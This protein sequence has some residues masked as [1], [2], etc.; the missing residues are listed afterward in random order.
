MRRFNR[1]SV[2]DMMEE[3]GGPQR[4]KAEPARDDLSDVLPTD[5][6]VLAKEASMSIADVIPAVQALSRGEKFQLAQMLFQDLAREELPAMFKAGPV[7]PMC[8]RFTPPS[9]P[10]GR[11]DLDN[12]RP[13]ADH[14]VK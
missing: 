7:Y 4:S 14:K 13:T 2:A 3:K 12:S 11:S 5:P 8:I 1:S 9:M 6:R 10:P